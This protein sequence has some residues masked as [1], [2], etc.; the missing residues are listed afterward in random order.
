M[1]RECRGLDALAKTA[2][3]LDQ[4]LAAWPFTANKV[5]E[6]Y[7]IDSL[8]QLLEPVTA[9]LAGRDDGRSR[10]LTLSPSLHANAGDFET[11]AP[12][13]DQLHRRPS[14]GALSRGI[15]SAS[16]GGT[17]H[18]DWA[19]GAPQHHHGD[20]G[21]GAIASLDFHHER[22]G[23]RTERSRPLRRSYWICRVSVR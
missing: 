3:D 22:A 20:P 18:D 13:A 2:A 12:S 23:L 19:L 7:G 4:R 6:D 11:C 9:T 16:S 5:E 8:C 17:I 14:R 1:L 15:S 10:L 21:T